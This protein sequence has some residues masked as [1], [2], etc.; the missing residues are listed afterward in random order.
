MDVDPVV[1]EQILAVDDERDTDEVAV[2]K[3]DRRFAHELGR[4][5]RS[6]Q[7]RLAQRQ[8]RDDAVGQLVEL[9]SG[10]DLDH[11]S[12]GELDARDG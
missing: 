3:T 11:S 12:A 7:H 9:V 2:A 6:H 10:R 4:A 8:R 5:R 1:G